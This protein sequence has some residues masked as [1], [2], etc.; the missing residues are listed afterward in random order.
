LFA[1]CRVEKI[2]NPIDTTVFRPIDPAEARQMLDL[3][4]DKR[5]IA[6]LPSFNSAIKGAGEFEGM[7]K[8]LAREMPADDL[9]IICA[10][11]RQVAIDAPFE[12]RQLGH[13]ADKTR[14]AAFFSAADVT[15]IPSLE[16]TFS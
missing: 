8:R 12:I 16:E 1:G 11:R 7:L 15:V 6:Y 13:I 14:L 5:I 10:G 4:T 3:P 9:L 2:P